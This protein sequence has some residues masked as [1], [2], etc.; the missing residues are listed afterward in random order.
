MTDAD[1]TIRRVA[2]LSLSL[3]CL[4]RS[5]GEAGGEAPRFRGH[6][7][8]PLGPLKHARILRPTIGLPAIVR[9]G[10]RL[11]ILLGSQRR[12][13]RCR[14]T[15]SRDDLK[16]GA[17]EGRFDN[18]TGQKELWKC[19]VVV[20]A[21][22][23]CPLLYDLH[24]DTDGCSLVQ[25]NAVHVVPRLA[26]ELICIQITDTE[27]N[28]RDP[29]PARR[30]ASAIEEI[31]LIR[32]DFVIAT[33]DLT[34]DGR[35]AQFEMLIDLLGRLEVPVFTQIGNADYH[36]NEAVYFARVNAYRDYAVDLG[37]VHLAALDSG[38]NYKQSKG[39]YN[40]AL[41]NQGTGLIDEQIAW[42]DADLAEATPGSARLVFMHFPAVSQLGNRASIH[43]NRERF[44][45]CCARNGVAL[46]LSGHTHVDSVFDQA[47]KLYV[48]GLAPTTRPCYVQTAT[49]SS[50]TR[51][52]LLPYS[53]RLIR[54]SG[55]R[56]VSF[57]YDT[58]GDGRPDAMRSAPVGRVSVTFDPPN[59]GKASAVTATIKNGLNERLD[60]ATVVFLMSSSA[61]NGFAVEGG[62]Q[63]CVVPDGANVRVHVQARVNAR[64]ERVVRVVRR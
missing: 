42:L 61:E 44:K 64:S 26:D 53:Y 58:G 31:N 27:I 49:V 33:G 3:V 45:A 43:F 36:G 15:L 5:S 21:A 11:D 6:L 9:P 57:T 8:E 28:D 51:M 22:V 32:P 37:S 39:S 19:S 38:T 34:Y 41:D 4:L 40:F 50:H 24:L 35:A 56:V 20:P 25:P 10:D 47:E 54:M 60:R 62:R 14:I 55:G 17:T 13:N 23:T 7:H 52:P 59:D 1:R 29:S 16:I 18:I 2:V 30:L 12:P 63:L 48:A 46:V